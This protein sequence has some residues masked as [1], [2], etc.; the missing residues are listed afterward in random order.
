MRLVWYTKDEGRSAWGAVYHVRG[1]IIMRSLGAGGQ[2]FPTSA[3][4]TA[5]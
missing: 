3:L 2:L 4:H 1:V 5:W